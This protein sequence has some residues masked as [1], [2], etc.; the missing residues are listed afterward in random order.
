ML[1]SKTRWKIQPINEDYVQNLI[2][3]L[4]IPEVVARLLVQRGMVDVEDA[5]AFLY[6]ENQPF[7]DPF[8]LKGMDKA[9]E[10]IKEAI[11]SEELIMV[12]GDY[13]ADGVTSTSVM[14]TALQELGANVEFYIPNRFTEGYGPNEEAFRFAAEQGTGLIITVD[15]GISGINEA[16][17]LK[18]LSVDLIITDHHE[19]G[20]ELPDALAIIHPNHPK[21]DYPFKELAGVGVAFKVAHALLG[22]PPEHLLDLAAIGTIA[23]L[24]PLKGEN[25]LI[26]KKGLKALRQT[27]R[28][29]IHALCKEAGSNVAELD[30]ESVGFVIGPRLNAVGRLSDADP[31]VH[32]LMTEDSEEARALAAEIDAINKERQTIVSDITKEAIEQVETKYPL[33]HNRILVIEKEGWNPGV[34]GIV[35][36]RLVDRFYRPV[37]MLCK[38]PAT[39]KSKGSAR[40]IQG[41]NMFEELSQ[42]RDILPHFG[43][44]P[45][46]AGMTLLSEDVA[47]LRSRLNRQAEKLT[48]EDFVPITNVDTLTALMD[49]DLEAISQV[50]LLAPFGM[51]NPKPKVLIEQSSVASIRK[52]GANQNHLKM[53]LQNGQHTLDGIAFG[54]GEIADHVS[55]LAKV[56]VIGELSINEWNNTKKAQL[57]VKDIKVNDWQL[58]DVRGISQP[59]RWLSILPPKPQFIAFEQSTV[60]VFKGLIE[61]DAI[62]LI[63]N[64]RHAESCSIDYKHLV[65]LDLPK[66]EEILLSLI[67]NGVPT[68]IYVHFYQ[69]NPQFFSGMPPRD[70]FAWYY[71][72]LKKRQQF[73]L[74]KNG[75]ALANHK[76]WTKDTINFMTKVFFELEFVT[77][78]DGII[79]V[80]NSV[81]KRDLSHSPAYQS[82]E[83]MVKLEQELLYSSFQQLKQWFEQHI[84]LT[85]RLE[86]EEKVWI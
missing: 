26:V 64:A 20:P 62:C 3:A 15:N 82:K 56:D 86:E 53:T 58:F 65:L 22:K 81:Q 31:A 24:V 44:H 8:L 14:L 74:Q 30:E 25:R 85:K 68:R 84:D 48:E 29:G 12:Y 70:N 63:G 19:P 54:L 28:T 77:M 42:N 57:F 5:K 47:E 21:G 76:G 69:E 1:Q 75:E 61:E 46:A 66:E 52:I 17:L 59:K 40:S 23:D 51:K 36:S 10:R 27:K 4:T 2:D 9:T 83:R 32:L 41:F 38:D 7:H 45:M 71:A 18:E 78:K 35:A 80:N 73:D 43:G 16:A 33:D 37:I 13:D 6:I 50:Q 55:P 39:G 11:A 72:F 79:T 49:V 67:R 34:V 60:E